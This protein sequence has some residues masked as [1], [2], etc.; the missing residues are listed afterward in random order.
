MLDWVDSFT[1]SVRVEFEILA[2]SGWRTFRPEIYGRA[3]ERAP[4]SPNEGR[5]PNV[6]HLDLVTV[7]LVRQKRALA[8]L[9]W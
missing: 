5:R 6:E 9:P 1:G 8:T 4:A 2:D 7:G 3:P